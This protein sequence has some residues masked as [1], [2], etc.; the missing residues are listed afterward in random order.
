MLCR[1]CKYSNHDAEG[2]RLDRSSGTTT[3]DDELVCRFNPPDLRQGFP[4]V[5]EACG[6]YSART[7]APGPLD[8]VF[9]DLT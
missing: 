8:K 5:R 4:R 6:E 2:S 7:V 1:D 3:T 9:L